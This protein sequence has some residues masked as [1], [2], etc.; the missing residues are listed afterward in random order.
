MLAN[1]WLQSEDNMVDSSLPQRPVQ[2]ILYQ[3]HPAMKEESKIHKY[4][5]TCWWM[6]IAEASEFCWSRSSV[7]KDDQNNLIGF[8]YLSQTW[9]LRVPWHFTVTFQQMLWLNKVRKSQ[10]GT[11]SSLKMWLPFKQL[12]FPTDPLSED[13]G[14]QSIIP[15]WIMKPKMRL[16][17]TPVILT[18]AAG[19]QF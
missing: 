2:N 17:T 5:S 19:C 18:K 3:D 14:S 6:H 11:W 7:R 1:T 4:R 10:S 16:Y 12:F 13:L 8:S 15:P 9:P